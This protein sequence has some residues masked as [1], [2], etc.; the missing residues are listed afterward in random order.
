MSILQH[1]MD[2]L[3]PYNPYEYCRQ[4]D[5]EQ[6]YKQEKGCT[7]ITIEGIISLCIIGAIFLLL[8]MLTGCSTKKESSYI[9]QRRMEA[10]MNRM[11][12]LSHVR[13]VVQQDSTWREVVMRQL[14]SIREKS[15]TS[16]YVVQDSL[17]NTI[18]EKIVINNIRETASETDRKEMAVMTRKIETMDST[19]NTM[20][21]QISMFESLLKQKEKVT[22]VEKPLSMWQQARIWL[23]NMVLVALALLAIAWLLRK[24]LRWKP[25]E[26]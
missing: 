24:Q 8:G 9:E 2:P 6:E 20:H 14:Q 19:I 5:G 13:T 1:H 11:D 4:N 3:D 22:Q 15:D 26:Q 23:G 25:S 16:R 17:G 7:L 21:Q 18:R 12:S 10:L